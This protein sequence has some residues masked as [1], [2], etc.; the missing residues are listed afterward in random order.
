MPK[1]NRPD[2]DERRLASDPRAFDASMVHSMLRWADLQHP[3]YSGD[4]TLSRQAADCF[5]WVSRVLRARAA[6]LGV[7]TRLVRWRDVP[8]TF[9]SHWFV[10]EPAVI[11]E[12]WAVLRPKQ[13]RDAELWLAQTIRSI[14]LAGCMG[15]ESGASRKQVLP[16]L[17]TVDECVAYAFAAALDEENGFRSQVRRCKY[18]SADVSIH[19]YLDLGKYGELQVGAPKLYCCESHA[20]R[21]RQAQ[22]RRRQKVRK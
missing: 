6:A 5:C 2:F 11:C 7:S 22:Y 14:R 20:N 21:D 1:L 19:H 16:L 17:T 8:S 15:F 12:M 3:R 4:I 9:S 13:R 10:R 18:A